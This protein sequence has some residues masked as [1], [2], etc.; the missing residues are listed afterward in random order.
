MIIYG[1]RTVDLKTVHLPIACTNCEHDHQS[2]Q[3]YRH[4]FSLY[5]IPVIPFRKSGLISC[6]S[7]LRQLKK[8]TFLKELTAK[9][10]DS[11]QA[12]L[13]FE[14]I[15]KSAQ[16]PL[17]MYLAPFLLAIATILFFAYSYHH[18]QREKA[19][20]E[21]YHQN[22]V[23]NVIAVIKS[24]ENSAY[25]FLISYIAE[26]G[27][28]TSVVFDWKYSYETLE[29]ANQ[30]VDMAYKI[31]NKNKLKDDFDGPYVVRTDNVKT[32]DIVRVRTLGKTINWKA[33]APLPPFLPGIN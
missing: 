24:T 28:E 21:Q 22:P 3:I 7:C 19:F 12:K 16:T 1:I 31:I 14:S 4:Y 26:V 27:K 32:I 10:F 23:G 15:F 29:D 11:T 13:H 17:Y 18:N 8:K 9:G 6:P 20:A 33:S 25:P 5:F 2:L 30:A